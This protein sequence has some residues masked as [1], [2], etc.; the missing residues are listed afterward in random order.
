MSEEAK[1]YLLHTYAGYENIVKANLEQMAENNNLQDIITDIVI[2][3]EQIIEEKNGKQ[4]VIENKIFPCYVYVKLVY[5]SQIWF[6]LTNT[7]G[8]TG[9]VGP[10]GKAWPLSAE[11]VKRLHLETKVTNFTMVVGDKVKVVSG[12]FEGMV[13]EIKTIDKEHQ[14]VNV[15]LLFFGRETNVDMDFIQIESIGNLV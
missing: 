12:P 6:L 3:T 15:A 9:F 14:K 13:G 4:R 5:S 2:P 8:V 10:S 11:E 7:R 1:W